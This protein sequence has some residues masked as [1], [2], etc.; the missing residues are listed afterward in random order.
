[1]LTKEQKAHWHPTKNSELNPDTLGSKSHKDA[2][3][4]CEQNHEWNTK[5]S[6]FTSKCPFCS[7]RKVLKGFNDLETLYPELLDEWDYEKNII[8][9]NEILYKSSDKT[10]WKCVNNH[11]WNTALRNRTIFNS[12]CSY[13]IDKKLWVGFNDIETK[14]PEVLEYWDYN[15]NTVT[16][17]NVIYNSRNTF[18]WRNPECGHEWKAS[19]FN[20]RL[21]KQKCPYCANRN[22]KQGV[23]DFVTKY[24]EIFKEW[25]YEKNLIDPKS[26]KSDD[27]TKYW[28]IGQE[29]NHSWTQ[30]V[31]KRVYR[32]SGCIYCKNQKVLKGFNDLATTRPDLAKAWSAKNKIQP[33]ELISRTNKKIILEC[34]YGHETTVN[35]KSVFT[36]KQFCKVCLNRKL[37]KGFN[38]F[39]TKQPL[40][41]EEWSSKNS[42]LPSEVIF[43]SDKEVLW[44]CKEKNHIW[45]K[46]PKLRAAYPS[47]PECL[48][49]S[50]SSKAEIEILEYIQKQFKYDIKTNVRNIL[51]KS[52]IDIY[53]SSLNLGIEYNGIHWHSTQYK[54]EKYHLSKYLKA[55]SK[56]ICLIQASEYD[57]FTN[58]DLTLS[59]IDAYFDNKQYDIS[60]FISEKQNNEINISY[61]EKW[62]GKAI[63]VENLNEN[64]VIIKNIISTI[65]IESLLR[66][67]MRAFSGKKIIFEQN[68]EWPLPSKTIKNLNLSIYEFIPPTIIDYLFRG[69]N[70][71]VWDAGKTCFSVNTDII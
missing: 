20:F 6:K 36:Q 55:R 13:C 45:N 5:I 42:L 61:N 64:L 17:N 67:T 50:Y 51:P 60:N 7:G 21:A 4:K 69:Q 70:Y 43:N 59:R 27:L 23:N 46:S 26:I 12:K 62:V 9:P 18:M 37:F 40:L 48:A 30:S 31:N 3:W 8:K 35:L 39:A 66:E 11:T 44:V 22:V 16:P 52:E 38:D 25:D 29:C 24:P 14:I 10:Y 32:N 41:A 19:L 54:K 28:W 2:W 34:E 33:D 71:S 15:K 58:R 53:I 1:M 63:F 49:N 56:N 65:S 68:N 47:C 57:Y